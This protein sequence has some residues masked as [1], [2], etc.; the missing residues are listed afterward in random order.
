MTRHFDLSVYLITDP[1]LCAR[2]GLVDTVLAAVRGG[3]TMVQLRDKQAAETELVARG[4]LLHRA[5]RG[6][7]V[8]LIVND[9]PELAAAIGAEGVHLGQTDGD[10][11]QARALLGPGAIIGR[12]VNDPGQLLEVDASD[13]DYFGVGP[14]F[15]TGTKRD[16]KRPIGFDGLARICARS[17]LP[18]V[19]IAGLRAEH[20][21]EVHRA[22]ARGLALVSAICAAEDPAAAAGEVAAAWAAVQNDQ[23][24]TP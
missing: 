1:L 11:A 10:A 3:V 2:R 15:A 19:A 21:A 14:V 4:R 13:V 5:L 23:E 7:T 6:S 18:V 9:R 8:P 17:S 20:A 22:G 12:S 16:H 24:T